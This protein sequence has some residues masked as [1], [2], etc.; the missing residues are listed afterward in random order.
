MAGVHLQIPSNNCVTEVYVNGQKA[1]TIWC[2]PWGLDISSYIRKGKNELE[3]HVTNSWNNRAI[4][5]LGQDRN[6]RL[7]AEPEAFVSEHSALQDAGLE[8]EVLLKF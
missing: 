7:I 5:D 1:G 6:S 4:D 8:G 3:L 2:S